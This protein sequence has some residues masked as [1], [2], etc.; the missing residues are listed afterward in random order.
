MGRFQEVSGFDPRG[1][2]G[3]VCGW[4][5]TDATPPPVMY[6]MAYV[7]AKLTS[8]KGRVADY[9]EIS[10]WS[11]V[12]QDVSLPFDSTDLGTY[13]EQVARSLGFGDSAALPVVFRFV[14]QR[15]VYNPTQGAPRAKSFVEWKP[16]PGIFR[17][18][19]RRVGWIAA[20]VI[21]AGLPSHAYSW[22]SGV[23]VGSG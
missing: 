7:E 5:V 3:T 12:R 6:H 9:G 17:V 14:G 22:Y 16:R 19:L 15:R 21:L 2:D 1:S 11:T 4:S 20:L 18:T 10:A 13:T 23:S 8:P